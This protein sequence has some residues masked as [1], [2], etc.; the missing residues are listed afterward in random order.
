MP[1]TTSKLPPTPHYKLNA[2][3]CFFIDKQK[4]FFNWS[5]HKQQKEYLPPLLSIC[6]ATKASSLLSKY[7]F[8]YPAIILSPYSCLYLETTFSTTSCVAPR[9]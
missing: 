2:F 3:K 9:K 8:L 1:E 7:P 5:R 4:I 6:L